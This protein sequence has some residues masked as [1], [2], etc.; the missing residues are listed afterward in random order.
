MTRCHANVTSAASHYFDPEELFLT[1]H[2]KAKHGAPVIRTKSLA[3]EEFYVLAPQRDP[4]Q[5][6]RYLFSKFTA[7]DEMFAHTLKLVG[8]A[9][10]TTAAVVSLFRNLKLAQLA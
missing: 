8:F 5:S 3:P 4:A 9:S 2:N 6:G 10:N 7:D 1:N